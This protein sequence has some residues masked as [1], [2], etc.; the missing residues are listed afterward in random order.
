MEPKNCFILLAAR[1]QTSSD[2]ILVSCSAFVKVKLK[3][4]IFLVFSAIGYDG[5]WVNADVFNHRPVWCYNE[6]G[7]PKNG[8]GRG[9]EKLL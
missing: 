4:R 7:K 5:P 1:C 2:N 6:K 9:L 3:N 8:P